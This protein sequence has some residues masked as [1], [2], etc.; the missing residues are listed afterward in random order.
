MSA[1]D[2]ATRIP[3]ASMT[4]IFSAAVPLPPEMIAPAWP[5]RRPGGAVCP[6][7]KP[8]TG[9]FIFVLTNSAAVSSAS[10][11]ISPIMTI[12]EVGSDNRIAAYADGGGLSD[13]ALRE[14]MNGFVSE[15]A[16]ARD[17]ADRTFFV[18]RSRHNS[19]FAFAGRNDAGAIWADQPRAAILQKLP[20]FDHVERGNAFGDADDEIELGVCG[21]HDGVGGERR[22]DEDHGGVGAGFFH[23]FL[24]RVENVPSFVRGA[25]FAGSDSTDHLRSVSGAGFGVEGAFAPGEALHD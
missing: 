9:F 7:M 1:G 24:H 16:G 19:D 12:E 21:F 3:A 17:D 22:R 8:T 25:A 13:A 23:G 6:A 18:N 5:M 15:C 2:F 11:P 20:G 4:L 14:L 10:P